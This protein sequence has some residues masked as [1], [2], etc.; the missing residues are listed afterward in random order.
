MKIQKEVYHLFVTYTRE[1]TAGRMV[2][3]EVTLT[4]NHILHLVTGTAEESILGFVLYPS[5][6][7][8]L[9]NKVHIGISELS[10]GTGSNEE[11]YLSA[12][13]KLQQDKDDE[14][15]NVPQKMK[16]VGGFRPTSPT[17]I[18]V[19]KLLR[20]SMQLPLPDKEFPYSQYDMAFSDSYFGYQ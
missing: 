7:F 15:E 6:E 18:N 10:H 4:L 14:N 11:T 2:C 1:V 20:A 8:T 3:G 16:I 12:E 13:V 5:I 9:P 19:L 17:C